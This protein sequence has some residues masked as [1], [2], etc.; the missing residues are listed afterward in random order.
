MTSTNLTEL[1]VC[2]DALIMVESS[3]VGDVLNPSTPKEVTCSRM[4]D[5][6]I[7]SLF[8]RHPWSFV[9]KQRQ[10]QIDADKTA[11]GGY[12][13]AFRLPS[14]LVGGPFAVFADGDLQ[15]PVSDFLIQGDYVHA[16][17]TRVDVT[18]RIAPTPDIWPEYFRLL[19]TKAVAAN[20]AKPIASNTDLQTELRIEVYGDANGTGTGG[21][22]GEAKKLDA[23]TKPIKSMFQNGNP[24]TTARFGGLAGFDI[25]RFRTP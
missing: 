8:A 18:Y 22:F 16:N 1:D 25:Q 23:Q 6:T 21:I 12:T 20:L 9:N 24:L 14:D 15:N 4:Y 19:G 11:E 3:P 17:Y 10:I 7:K 5:L 13:R 2:N